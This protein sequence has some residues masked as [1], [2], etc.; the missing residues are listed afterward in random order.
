MPTCRAVVPMMMGLSL[1]GS[2]IIQAAESP[3]SEPVRLNDIHTYAVPSG[4]G[5]FV[6]VGSL[7]FF[8]A[9]SN[10]YGRELWVTDATAAGTH[11]VADLRS[12]SLSSNPQQLVAMGGN[13]YFVANDGVSGDELWTSDGTAVGTTLVK[14]IRTGGTGASITD[15]RVIGGWLYF[16]ANDGTTGAELWR[17]DGTSAGTTLV[18]DLRSGSASSTPAAFV[19]SGSSVYFTADDG[20]SG[21]ELWVT[22]GTSAGTTLVVDAVIGSGSPAI[23]QLTYANGLAY[24]T[25]TTAT[26]GQELWRSDGTAAGTFGLDLVA[27]ATGST[28]T[29]LTPFGAGLAF[30]ATTAAHGAELWTSDGTLAGTSLVTDLRSG[31]TGSSPAELTVW[32]G[33]VVFQANDGTTGAELWASDGTSAG[34]YQIADIV[35][36]SGS[37]SPVSLLGVG[38]QLYFVAYT[39][40]TGYEAWVSDGTSAGTAITKDIVPS[41]QSSSPLYLSPRPDG[42]GILFSANDLAHHVELWT[43]QGTLATTE[44]VKEIAEGTATA[45]PV[46]LTDLNGTL[47]FTAIEGQRGAELWR[48]DGAPANTILVKDLRNGWQ[49]S[50]PNDQIA[51]NGLVYFSADDGSSGREL[52]VSDGTAAGSVLFADIRSGSGSSSPT[53]F[54][55]A[56]GLLFFAADNGSQGSELWKTDGTLAGTVLVKDIRSGSASSSIAWMTTVG[57]KVFF[58]ADDG[59]NGP[60]LWVSD[61]TAAGTFL[62]KDIRPGSAG[63]A[64][65]SLVELNG[66]AYF[67]AV[68]GT[69]GRELW[70]SDGTTAGTTMVVD[71][72]SGPYDGFREGND[73]LAAYDGKLYFCGWNNGSPATNSIICSDGTAAGTAPLVPLSGIS[74]IYQDQ[75]TVTTAGLFYAGTSPAEGQE[76][77]V[78]D[79]TAAGTKLVADIHAGS[80]DAR[81]R[82]LTAVPGGLVFSATDGVHG[83][84]FW[85]TDG[86]TT[87]MVADLWPGELGS[88][89]DSWVSPRS[90]LAIGSRVYVAANDG[91]TGEELWTFVVRQMPILT[92]NT[93]AAIPAGTALGAAQL[94]ATA[95]VPG[96]FTYDPIAGTVLGVGSHL[97]TATFT[98]TDPDL[99]FSG[100]VQVTLEV[101][102]A[103]QAP[104]ITAGPSIAQ[105]PV[106]GVSTTLSVA[107]DDDG[108]PANL[109]VT[110][111]RQAGPEE[112]TFAPNGTSGSTAPTA[113]FQAAGAYTIRVTITD[114]QGLFTTADLPVT[115]S[116]TPT[117]VT[118]TPATATIFT[119]GTQAFSAS[120][121]DQFT[122]PIASPTVTWSVDALASIDA[123]GLLTAGG[124][125]GTATVTGTSGSASDT[126]TVT[127][128]SA[129]NL[130]PTVV[131]APHAVENPVLGPLVPIA[132]LGADDAGEANLTYTW[133]QTS[134]PGTVILP[135]GNGTYAGRAM[136]ARFPQT[137]AYGFEVTIT[138]SQ[139]ESVV[140]TG[141]I[142]VTALRPVVLD[143]V[144]AAGVNYTSLEQSLI[145]E[146]PNQLGMGLAFTITAAPSHGTAIMR[147][148]QRSFRYTPATGF[149]GTDQFTVTASDGSSTSLPALITVTVGTDPQ[150]ALMTRSPAA[151]AFDLEAWQSDQ[152]YVEGYLTHSVPGRVWQTAAGAPDV[153]MLRLVGQASIP[154]PVNSLVYIQAISR[155]LAPVTFTA[156]GNGTFGNVTSVTVQADASGLATVALTAPPIASRCPV[157]IGSPLAV[158]TQRV[159][160]EAQP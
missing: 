85:Y 147:P 81:P 112:I 26:L 64:L 15:L 154:A 160:V 106:D 142:T 153:P 7:S 61:G 134:G 39:P 70:V 95:N 139:N 137:G 68:D 56:N 152:G 133:V 126:A 80:A 115:V 20:T 156:T 45:A 50:N 38:S 66:L 2:G 158:G 150:R 78:T 57:T 82:R 109:T 69:H 110:W 114:A 29:S 151:L 96:T 27:G 130:P 118:V 52:W 89:R 34:T 67:G 40:T 86:T 119:G 35:S 84:E 11:Q 25:A 48:S 36:G 77:W 104:T 4:P 47:V 31:S 59:I 149:A 74:S 101:Q 136:T 125:P 92:W 93:P 108:G 19:G 116:A 58:R 145:G 148:N 97:L 72:R 131:T 28:P 12:G 37:S 17:S 23:A 43:S 49:G 46:Y 10:G 18:K 88:V 94:N 127:I 99:Y 129:V 117:T 100:T 90:T 141:T 32:N 75:F 138:D 122:D 5:P 128:Q 63:S 83:E 24:Y 30:V 102:P 123:S 41:G 16:S 73:G 21:R 111:T 8:A 98:P 157:L 103:N 55:V 135:S 105:D 1:L 146:D 121:T 33:E 140:T 54:A 14:D 13:V 44:M 144:F 71:L 60:E 87:L 42:T 132:V 120:V 65:F 107:V 143:Q 124:S 159:V 79:G 53:Q 6:T 62:V 22:D 155:P 91:Q 76:L 3:V 113:T 51:W 9:T